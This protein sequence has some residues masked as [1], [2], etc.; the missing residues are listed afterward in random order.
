M[1]D[2]SVARSVT[3]WAAQ[4]IDTDDD[5][6]KLRHLASG[7]GYGSVTATLGGTV[8]D[9]DTV[10]IRLSATELELP[11]GSSLSYNVA[12]ATRP[13][14]NVTVT[15]NLSGDIAGMTLKD[16]Q[17]G[18]PK[19]HHLAFTTDNWLI[20]QSVTVESV[21][22]D[23][24]TFDQIILTHS[25]TQSADYGAAARSLTIR[26]VNNDGGFLIS[27][28]AM[29]VGE[30]SSATYSLHLATRPA[31]AVTVTVEDQ[32]DPDIF[33]DIDGIISAG[34]SQ[35]L[36]FA[37]DVWA[38]AQTVTVFAQSDLDAEDGT[39]RLNHTASGG[40]YDA[41]TGAVAVTE[42]DSDQ[43]GLILTA[44]PV[45]VTEGSSAVYAVRL[46]SLPSA[47]V[48]VTVAPTAST[49]A[50]LKSLSGGA[51]AQLVFGTG[52]YS[53]LQ[54]VTVAPIDDS[55][56]NDSL[57][58]LA[59]TVS[60]GGYDEQTA[61]Q[62]VVVADD[63]SKGFLFAPAQL[64][65][66]EGSSESY[67]VR[68][69]TQPASNVTV[70]IIA[71]GDSDITIDDTDPQTIGK[72]RTLTFT[73]TDWSTAQSVTLS[74]AE[75][76][77]GQQGLTRLVHSVTGGDYDGITGTLVAT[78]LDDEAGL[79][80]TPAQLAVREG[81]SATYKLA[82]SKQPS[83]A[84]TV[85]AS[86]SALSDFRFCDTQGNSCLTE[87]F[88]I[89]AADW[90][91]GQTV[92][93]WA[94]HDEDGDDGSAP[95]GHRAS[96]TDA[97]YQAVAGPLAATEIDDDS[98]RLEFRPASAIAPEGGRSYYSARLAT[99]PR[100]TVT[101]TIDK[102]SGDGDIS[103]DT[104]LGTPGLQNRLTFDAAVWSDWQDVG[105]AA[106]EDDDG[107]AG[108]TLFAHQASGHRYQG[109]ET[110]LTVTE[111]DN[112]AK[113]L[114]LPSS[115]LIVPE[116]G[117]STY[118]VSLR[119][120]PT[121][122]VTVS[123]SL[124]GDASLK[125]RDPTTQVD[126]TAVTLSFGTDNYATPQTLTLS[127]AADSDSIDGR[128]TLAH[129]VNGGGYGNFPAT[130]TVSEADD[131][132]AGF[133]FSSGYGFRSG[134]VTVTEGQTSTYQIRLRTEPTAPVTV[135]IAPDEGLVKL[136]DTEPDRDGFQ[137]T[138]TFTPENWATVRTV[139]M[140]MP[141]DDVSNPVRVRFVHSASG[142]DYGA[143]D[144]SGVSGAVITAQVWDNDRIRR[145]IVT[146][147]GAH[148]EEGG[149]VQVGVRL[150]H[151]PLSARYGVTLNVTNE[152]VSGESDDDIFLT[153]AN[154]RNS[155][156]RWVADLTF[157]QDNYATLQLLTLTAR[158]DAD[159]EDGVRRLKATGTSGLYYQGIST[160]FK[161]TEIDNDLPGLVLTP[162]DVVVTEGGSATYAVNL[163]TRPSGPVTV[164]LSLPGG[165]DSGVSIADL[166]A[167]LPGLQDALTFT[168]DNFA[169]AQTVTVNA[170]RDSDVEDESATVR[171]RLAGGG[172]D[173]FTGTVAIKVVD[174]DQPR[175]L[176]TNTSISLSEGNSSSYS[177]IF[178]ARPSGD[179]TV[180][181]SHSGDP[182]LVVDTD[183][184]QEGAQS[185]LVFTTADY[186]QNRPATVSLS[187]LP[188]DDGVN[189]TAT[190]VH[191]A[192]GGSYGSVTATL[193]LRELDD[194]PGFRITPSALAVPEN[195]SATYRVRLNTQPGSLVAVLVS[196]AGDRNI[197]NAP[198]VLTFTTA[199]WSTEQVVTLKAADDSDSE[200]GATEFSHK[201]VGGG[202]RN[203]GILRISA[204]E[205]D[206]DLP[207]F[208]FDPAALDIEEGTSGVYAVRLTAEPTAAVTVTA[209]ATRRDTGARVTQELSLSGGGGVGDQVILTFAPDQF[210]S[211][212]SLTIAAPE[213]TDSAGDAF[214]I[215]HHASGGGYG[216]VDWNSGDAGAISVDVA[217]NDVQRIF[218]EPVRLAVSEGSA[219][220]YTIRLAA[221]PAGNLV[222]TAKPSGDPGFSVDADDRLAGR[223]DRLTFNSHDYFAPRT[224]T[225][226]SAAD[227]DAL[228][229]VGVI[230]HEAVG[231][232]TAPLNV[233]EIDATRVVP[234][235]TLTPAS[236]TVSELGSAA[237]DVK[238]TK[239]PSANVTVSLAISGDG[240]LLLD[241]DP[242]TSGQ[243]AEHLT[244]TQNDWNTAQ[245]VLVL[246]QSDEDAADGTARIS[247][248]ATGGGYSGI[249]EAT[250]VV[251]EVAERDNKPSL[252]VT[253]SLD[254]SNPLDPGTQVMTV[255][256][257]TTQ[258][259]FARLKAKPGGDVTVSVSIF[260]VGGESDIAFSDDE[261]TATLTFSP[262][263]FSAYQQLTLAAAED[264]D[265]TQGLVR[266]I[267]R[268]EGGGYTGIR[269][270][271][272]LVYEVDNDAGIQLLPPVMYLT[273]GT[274][275]ELRVRL[276]TDPGTNATTNIART[277]TVSGEKTAGGL[278]FTDDFGPQ[279][280]S[281]A[282]LT[283]STD[284]YS[285]ALTLG[286]ITISEDDDANV[287]VAVFEFSATNSDSS[288]TDI[289][290]T[291]SL[292]VT[293]LET[294]RTGLSIEAVGG[295]IF[296]AADAVLSEGASG[297]FTA[298]LTSRPR[299]T[300]YVDVA[301][302][303]EGSLEVDRERL[304]F[305]TANWN[306]AQTVSVTA[307]HD[308]DA[309]NEAIGITFD[310]TDS[311]FGPAPRDYGFDWTVTD[312]DRKGLS[313]SVANITVGE[314][315]SAVY[316][317]NLE[318]RP[319][320]P[321]TVT[322]A[323][324]G[325]VDLSVAD[326]DPGT[327]GD[328]QA[329][330]FSAGNYAVA[331]SVTLLAG[332]DADSG[333]G[334][335]RVTHTA[336]GGGYDGVTA[337][338]NATENDDDFVGLVLSPTELTV[339]EGEEAVWTLR[340]ATPPTGQVTAAIGTSGDPDLQVLDVEPDVAGYQYRL[341]FSVNNWS[342]AQSVTLSAISDAD[343]ADGVS[344]INLK[345]TGS[346]YTGVTASLSVTERDD[347]VPAI[348]A[349]PAGLRVREG[350]FAFYELQLATQ[351]NGPV[352]VSLSAADGDA[353][354][355][356][357]TD[358]VAAGNQD[359]VT[360]AANAYATAQTV[361]V[362]AQEDADGDQ[363]LATIRHRGQ[364]G[365]YS[366]IVADVGVTETDNE[367]GLRIT[368]AALSVAEG[369]SARYRIRLSTAPAA[370]VTVSLSLAGDSDLSLDA[371]PA[372]GIQDQVTFTTS[373]YSDEQTIVVAAAED[374]DGEAG[375]AIIS[376]NSAFFRAP[377]SIRV[378]ETD[379]DPKEIRFSV[380][381][382]SI[383]EGS[384]QTYGLHLA[385][386]PSDDVTVD[387]S[388]T[389]DAG[390]TAEPAQLVFSTTDFSLAQTM[391]VSVASDPDG[392]DGQAN[393]AHSASDGGYDG[394][395]EF[396]AVTER[397]I[398][399]KGFWKA[400]GSRSLASPLDSV[401]VS[402]G[403]TALY[404]V[405]LAT[406]PEGPVTVDVTLTGDIDF[407][408]DADADL[409][410]TQFGFVF[411][412]DNYSVAKSIRI[413]AGEDAD[414][415]NGR[416]L[417]SLL[418]RGGDYDGVA[419]ALIAVEADNDEESYLFTTR[420]L[421]VSENGT[422]SYALSLA[423]QPSAP[424][425]VTIAVEGD[426][427]IAVDTD[428]QTPGNQSTLTF[429]LAG[430][431][432]QQTVKVLAGNDADS[433]DGVARLRHSGRG[434]GYGGVG[435]AVSVRETDND[436]PGILLSDSSLTVAEG[437]T[438][439]YT[440]R[441]SA[442]PLAPVTVLVARQS[443]DD[444]LSASP[445]WLTF[446]TANFAT[447]Q[448]V[449]VSA[450]DDEIRTGRRAVFSHTASGGGYGG[451]I[452][453]LSARMT[454]NDAVGL[455]VA[456]GSLSL[457][458]GAAGVQTYTLR[459]KSRPS[460]AVTVTAAVIGD[461]LGLS[462]LDD[463][464]RLTFTA[465]NYSAARTLT[466][467]GIE[468]ADGEHPGQLSVVHS[469]SGA[470]YRNVSPLTLP[471][472]VKDDDAKIMVLSATE[473][474][475]S[476]GSSAV[477]TA[478]LNVAPTEDVSINVAVIGGSGLTVSTDETRAPGSLARLEFTTW[479]WMA[480]QTVT[481]HAAEDDSGEALTNV[482]VNFRSPD[483]HYTDGE[484]RS[485][486]LF[487]SRVNNDVKALILPAAKQ[488]VAEGSS[489]G[490]KLGL[491]TKPTGD[492]VVTLALAAGS[493]GDIAVGDTDRASSGVQNSLTFTATNYSLGQTVTLLAA[494]DDDA[495]DG[496]ATLEI[497]A[498]GGGYDGLTGRLT[499]REKDDDGRG[500][501][502]S[503]RDVAVSEGGS[504]TYGV[505]LNY[506]P[507]ASV[508]AT[509][510]VA[511]LAPGVASDSSISADTDG[512]TAGS[513]N[514]LTFTTDNYAVAQTVTVTA[515]EDSDSVQG[516]AR[517]VHR[518]GTDASDIIITELENEKSIL[519]SGLALSVSEA[520]VASYGLS[521]AAEP[522]ASVTVTVQA[523][524]GSGA[525]T[526]L[527][528]TGASSFT[529][530]TDNWNSVRSVTL[531]AARDDADDS[532]GTRNFLHSASGG[533][534]ATV[535]TATLVATEIDSDHAEIYLET[536]A[537]NALTI[538]EIDLTEG[539]IGSYFVSLTM[540]VPAGQAVTVSVIP[541]SPS[542]VT[543]PNTP[544]LIF[545]RNNH[546]DVGVNF[547]ALEDADLADR[548]ETILFDG[549]TGAFSD[550][551][552]TL[553][554][555]II[556]NDSAGFAFTTEPVDGHGRDVGRL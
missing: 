491:A 21:D 459:L 437:S 267:H 304:S 196:A 423:T 81:G 467:S 386:Q 351:P 76:S 400:D 554:V 409:P 182:D 290:R 5:D 282:V 164:S 325:D 322:V 233:T 112:D 13:V 463:G 77:Q 494:A 244:F 337:Q 271:R 276:N 509:V 347:D 36:T 266:I 424:V 128:A 261:T 256:E 551:A 428:P 165:G 40:G 449:T 78:E 225:V 510:A 235:L 360:F 374:V 445:R 399:P 38:V 167:D 469:V 139:S 277:V 334:V 122:A 354:I 91:T 92:T 297:S 539:T 274:S 213:D 90:S 538:A 352:T 33:A 478:R 153:G 83:A 504:A 211:A 421:L 123:I 458:E 310:V 11:E 326:T 132:S 243:Q 114:D 227:N 278:G 107:D 397:D 447:P 336:S 41:V 111:G 117:V 328:Q 208:A 283:F 192:S 349:T 392:N 27:T 367:P 292:R 532:A 529:F 218:V 378:S 530:E 234:G 125:I 376:H 22:D 142:G 259:Y 157:T 118:A 318:T 313:L 55:D 462:G 179:V 471:V 265:G 300:V 405:K 517:L 61:M 249:P 524:T 44:G 134:T 372:P 95:I 408:F 448:T 195:G 88:E 398:N 414:G 8:T 519:L 127:A 356:F 45:T 212:Q 431:A 52:N 457:T 159:A 432:I 358:P 68:L 194:E 197:T 65:I 28:G 131:D 70:T 255:D 520:G 455:A 314:G 511:E 446:G 506:R 25:V 166:D 275:G 185:S 298:R 140:T 113:G 293:E 383:S 465:A 130:L 543:I 452:A 173:S 100:G 106:A 187:A 154:T 410:G 436:N 425:T 544:T 229:G 203:A 500:F 54:S 37:P 439:S 499:V 17:P 171:H 129:R 155:L 542:I 260:G 470:D 552:T 522:S 49:A 550:V 126:G 556:D 245:T 343:G 395:T 316:S 535:A 228:D 391:T 453:S 124:R 69:E 72:Q 332:H 279:N 108:E 366:G 23:A 518:S 1:S 253:L 501:L 531:S 507:S 250:D 324:G 242:L 29:S 339:D 180:T 317:V 24:H 393:L 236:L 548:T 418:A 158:E 492:V 340:L 210:A 223:Q 396:L 71:Y 280:G 189:G 160:D 301:S 175:L 4:D 200:N 553:T 162:A 86:A 472:D 2:Y 303:D 207:G 20:P 420:N 80:F 26:E 141:D 327:P 209:F 176:L 429:E 230:A 31:Q 93:L 120:K 443:G 540:D 19:Q 390:V 404:G 224:L 35:T 348:L 486:N 101:V 193:A 475:L 323:A 205:V 96:S 226:T 237:Y 51:T 103:L 284:N 16:T 547:S 15:I 188:D 178:P 273:E 169:T 18:P 60:G 508:T 406:R 533:D 422:A 264:D 32:G 476:E 388:R 98:R 272:L 389:G 487:V 433:A 251:L 407:S 480:P 110:T 50:W 12:L 231:V 309:E 512:V 299:S 286:S 163:A 241:T 516:Q 330:T 239:R 84:V 53:T 440:L 14:G 89:A 526:D 215:R 268:A 371:D 204:T 416:T 450:V 56:E 143:I 441:L 362:F 152:D 306:V 105:I 477:A 368:P 555:N 30:G 104:D 468:D 75:D 3:L 151:K 305:T 375:V 545:E 48:T 64:Q 505:R 385:T 217:D 345:A 156:G 403:S 342:V 335:A 311:Y 46:R 148:I 59:H 119:T 536:P 359:I 497:S 546:L 370:A 99:R 493:D 514:Q 116:G 484:G 296:G 442:R 481:L 479:N 513:Q 381:S 338:L 58:I 312:D 102:L 302:A 460:A 144:W 534:Y 490:F 341:T 402:E 85:T 344:R 219:L 136:L 232:Q 456:P 247:H 135:R 365:G 74:G 79:R 10:G 133:V 331:Q 435:G 319:T 382:L 63:D 262:D 34:E 174:N 109:V 288:S 172:Y 482:A 373:D 415:D 387:I 353:D 62:T 451:A 146:P 43:K 47:D 202:Y 240:D 377:A 42:T 346:S 66:S 221:N 181:I 438:S 246:A 357:D 394:V 320:A 161:V 7:G 308:S 363:G 315:S 413:S 537:G 412:T 291:V 9:D 380:A 473:I 216:S 466:L 503:A 541:S 258:A 281:Q 201:A 515:I 294:D 528:L 220:R 214:A 464:Q 333:D 147:V 289:Y 474:S 426:S 168:A 238:L 525:D 488:V 121:G 350:S 498:S 57:I 295:G 285:D 496:A 364:G 461:G 430:F 94:R 257:G 401:S 248:T 521:L 190:L 82:L 150:S 149:I 87:T 137:N 444:A 411:T 170:A 73:N 183:P 191:R 177:I 485:S 384:S 419:G 254:G 483:A 307:N 379:N 115:D 355:T 145:I 252:G 495:E 39:A 270:Q 222:V 489:S 184:D 138:L 329:L 269:L 427:D 369:G 434:G 263:N 549:L 361:T 287:G 206:D 67:S 502:F 527:T 417:V 97:D 6:F 199:N 186:D 523:Q 198:S 454:D 321:V